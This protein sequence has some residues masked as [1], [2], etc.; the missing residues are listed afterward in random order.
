[1]QTA[2]SLGLSSEAANRLA[3]SYGLIPSQV[4]TTVTTA[5]TAENTQLQV[6]SVFDKLKNLPPNTP[7]TVTGLTEDAIKKLNE[8]GVKTTTLPDGKIKVTAD[9]SG[10]ISALQSVV[11]QFQNKVITFFTGGKALGDIVENKHG[12]VMHYASGGMRTMSPRRAEI[13]K[14]NTWRI[15]GDRAI[16]DEAFI[17]INN[18][19]RSRALL[20]ETARRM[21]FSLMAD[22]DVRAARKLSTG[23]ST[24]IAAGAIVVNAPFAD[25][26]LVAK[27]T[28]N[29][30]ARE[31][32]A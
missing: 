4:L 10:A 30:L 28:L 2:T 18:A 3:D 27:A 25:P 24:T 5:G 22:G 9:T 16:G 14:P 32:V 21:G 1:V 11:R 20:A 31:A 29:A 8:V 12:N 15:I 17:P 13:V 26:A 6:Q 7:V 23:S 19:H